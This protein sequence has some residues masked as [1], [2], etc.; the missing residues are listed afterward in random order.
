MRQ[1]L[2][3]GVLLFAGSMLGIGDACAQVENYN[4]SRRARPMLNGVSFL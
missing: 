1:M 2:Y 3:C 4:E